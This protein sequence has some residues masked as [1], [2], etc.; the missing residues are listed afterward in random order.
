V[1]LIAVLVEALGKPGPEAPSPRRVGVGQ[2]R[3]LD[4]RSEPKAWLDCSA[5]SETS[6]ISTVAA[7]RQEAVIVTFG[8]V[9][10]E[11]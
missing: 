1:G 6:N 3:A 7:V 11:K 8:H 9:N 5:Q 4:G 10:P 2:R